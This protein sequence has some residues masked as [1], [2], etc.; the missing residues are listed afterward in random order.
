MHAL[1]SYMLSQNGAGLDLTDP[2]RNGVDKRTEL[3]DKVEVIGEP[4][5]GK[6]G[7]VPQTRAIA[8][9]TPARKRY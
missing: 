5:S 1:L 6:N 4:G 3:W 2:R 8:F 7:K 9:G